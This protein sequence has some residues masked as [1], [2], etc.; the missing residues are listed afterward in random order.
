[1]KRGFLSV[2]VA[3]VALWMVAGAGLVG[4]AGPGPAELEKARR[5]EVVDGDLD[6]ATKRYEAVVEQFKTSDRATAAQALL[7][8]AELYRKMG[9][10]AQENSA[11]ERLIKEF[12]DQP[13]PVAMARSRLN[14]SLATTPAALAFRRVSSGSFQAVVSPDGRYLAHDNW[15]LANRLIVRDLTTGT[16]R[17]YDTTGFAAVFSPDSSRIAYA[18][19]IDIR[20][21]EV[22][23]ANVRETPDQAP[24][25][26]FS[27]EGAYA[28]P[29]DWSP[30]GRTLAVFVNREADRVLQFGLLGVSNGAYRVLKT[31]EWGGGGIGGYFSPD[32]RDI[33]FNARVTGDAGKR[34]IYLMA[35]DASREVPV[36]TGPGD[37][38]VLGWTPDGKHLLFAANRANMSLWAQ[39]IVD[40][41]PSGSPMLVRNNVEPGIN[42]AGVTRAGVVH[43]GARVRAQN[44]EVVGFD[45]AT[46]TSVGAP[47]RPIR[48]VADYHRFPVWSP[49]GKAIAY[50][51]F[52]N[53]EYI[54]GVRTMDTG[55]E[56]ELKLGSGLDLINSIISWAPDGSFVAYGRDLKGRYGVF[57]I[58]GIDG[59]VTPLQ[60]QGP[61]GRAGQEG[62]FWS[63]DGKKMYYR[64]ATSG[65][66]WICERDLASGTERPIVDGQ[67]RSMAL[68]PDGK[69]FV[70]TRPEDAAALARGETSLFTVLLTPAAGGEQKELMRGVDVALNPQWMADSQAILLKATVAGMPEVWRVPIDGSAPRKLDIAVGGQF[71]LSPDGRQLVYNV[72]EEKNE[73]W[74]VENVLAVIA[75]K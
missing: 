49:D 47:S 55:A 18:H 43:L 10:A 39:A 36:V 24:R 42:P 41:K 26:I 58:D 46:G 72:G 23:T 6:A 30:D 56:R 31:V 53:S 60:Y 74:A 71:K 28:G 8:A 34:D 38:F 12:S 35:V 9:R 27:L 52:R 68:S 7:S 16:E 62:F 69:W 20:N 64:V 66:G 17:Q 54:L 63:P 50:T 13:K 44:V 51:S 15:P 33:A 29:M 70:L 5:V 21:C 75:G 67:F 1:M 37:E 48:S 59:N 22:R 73:V 4:Q 32:G 40:R 11:Y 45:P 61:Q 57:R 2:G 19:C 25:R 65:V 14:P 3:A